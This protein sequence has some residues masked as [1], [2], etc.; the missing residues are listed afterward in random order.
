MA[1]DPRL[2]GGQLDRVVFAHGLARKIG[3]QPGTAAGAVVRLMVD[4]AI[5]IRAHGA[6]VPVM[7]RL[8]A[9][10]LG[11]IPTLLAI[12]RGRL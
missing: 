12:R 3:C 10:G 5:D 7:A 11:L 9:T 1:L 6:A 2:D 8:G 4:E